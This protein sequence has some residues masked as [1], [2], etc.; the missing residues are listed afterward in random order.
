MVFGDSKALC[1]LLPGAISCTPSSG[2]VSHSISACRWWKSCLKNPHLGFGQKVLCSIPFL[3]PD[4]VALR[5]L[6]CFRLI[7]R[8]N[9]NHP[10]HHKIPYAVL[11]KALESPNSLWATGWK[12]WATLAIGKG[13]LIAWLTFRRVFTCMGKLFFSRE[14]V[15]YSDSC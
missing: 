15:R 5:C 1:F 2:R 7:H 10:K 9:G 11:L 13:E 14:S 12:R 6:T 3:G 4:T 8:G